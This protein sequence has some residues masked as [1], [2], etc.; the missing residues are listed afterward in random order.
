[1]AGL[2]TRAN[3]RFTVATSPARVS[4]PYWAAITSCPSA[5]SAGITLLKHE[6]SAQIPWQ[7]TMLFFDFVILVFFPLLAV[8]VEM[9]SPQFAF[10]SSPN[11]DAAKL[12]PIARR[13]I[14]HWEEG[15]L[16]L[17]EERKFT[18]RIARPVASKAMAYPLCV[19]LTAAHPFA[20][21]KSITLEQVAAEPL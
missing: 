7:N 10:V 18:R 13:A 5:C 15:A 9:S 11:R 3:V 2:L 6:P 1:M 16:L 19:A 14:G 4:R 20:R 8:L 12:P 17:K 21:L